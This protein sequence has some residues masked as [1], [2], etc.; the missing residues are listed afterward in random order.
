[1]DVDN[2]HRIPSMKSE[3]LEGRKSE[4]HGVL[5]GVAEAPTATGTKWNPCD[6]SPAD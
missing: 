3:Q 6:A 1:V 2:L 4:E 5:E